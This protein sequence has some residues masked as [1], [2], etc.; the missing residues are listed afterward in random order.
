MARHRYPF[1]GVDTASKVGHA[2]TKTPPEGLSPFRRTS[3]FKTTSPNGRSVRSQPFPDPTRSTP[4]LTSTFV[5]S[6]FQP[7]ALRP[8]K[9]GRKSWATDTLALSTATHTTA[10]IIGIL[11]ILPSLRVAFI[12]GMHLPTAQ[13]TGSR[14]RPESGSAQATSSRER[15]VAISIFM[16]PPPGG[17]CQH[18]R[19]SSRPPGS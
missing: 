11:P 3:I 17:R 4:L 15:C 10:T 6:A 16:L 14:R 2:R 1:V 9:S 5:Y 12:N 18:A 7:V 19:A 13:I 8:S